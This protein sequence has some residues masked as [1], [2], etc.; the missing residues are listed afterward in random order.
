MSGSHA[1][2]EQLIGI[3]GT[4][5]ITSTGDA[6]ESWGTNTDHQEESGS[7]CPRSCALEEKDQR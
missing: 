2:K 3:S 7:P 4:N 6:S 5:G 1:I